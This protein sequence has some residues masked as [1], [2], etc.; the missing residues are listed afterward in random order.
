MVGV[1]FGPCPF[2][3]ESIFH[4]LDALFFF[5]PNQEHGTFYVTTLIIPKQ[6]STSSSVSLWEPFTY[7][8]REDF[9]NI[10]FKGLFFIVLAANDVILGDSVKL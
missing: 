7:L 2:A 6:D 5:F 3:L 9:I 8:D 10:A 1:I 4:S